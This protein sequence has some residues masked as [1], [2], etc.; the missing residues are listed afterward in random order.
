MSTLSASLVQTLHRINSQK[1]DLNNQLQRGPK[2][3][4]ASEARL[5]AAEEHVHATKDKL[6][7]AKVESHSK[8]LQLSERE[9]KIRSWQ[10]KLNAAKENREYQALKDQIAADTQ[11]NLVLSDEIFELLESIDVQAIDLK[12]AES[13][14][15]A[16]KAEVSKVRQEVA[17]RRVVLEADLT[18]VLAELEKAEAELPGEVKRDYLKMVGSKAE[19]AMAELDGK[20]CGGCF[21]SLTPSILDRLL[22]GHAVNCPACGRFVYQNQDR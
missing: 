22:M 8:Q 10:G 9:Q 6:T 18:R 13:D 11:A 1:T 21:Q 3:V 5:K 15:D 4:A 2:M 14:V 19:D 12:A 20:C 17:D 16:K 7:K